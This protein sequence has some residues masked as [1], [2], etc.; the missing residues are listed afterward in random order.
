[1]ETL[2]KE[3]AVKVKFIEAQYESR[4]QEEAEAFYTRMNYKV[5]ALES[6]YKEVCYA[7]CCYHDV[8]K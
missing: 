6:Y 3:I 2:K 8:M 1:M 7:H 4:L 5:K